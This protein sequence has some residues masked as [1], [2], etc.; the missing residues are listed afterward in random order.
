[1]GTKRENI[2]VETY[3]LEKRSKPQT[4]WNKIVNV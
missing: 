1:M 4:Q 3:Q 2:I